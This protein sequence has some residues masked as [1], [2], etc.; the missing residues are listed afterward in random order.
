MSDKSSFSLKMAKFSETGG[1]NLVLKNRLTTFK[2]V[3]C[4][5]IS[6]V[7]KDEFGDYKAN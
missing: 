1:F 3:G 5:K 2:Y 6:H 7:F 4:L